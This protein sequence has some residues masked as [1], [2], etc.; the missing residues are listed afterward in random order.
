MLAP[1]GTPRPVLHQISKEVRRIFELPDVKER[2][3]NYDY[4]LAPTTPE[5]LDQILKADIA[6]FSEVVTLAGLRAK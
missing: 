3:K 5:E 4:F 2:L 1:A 6:T